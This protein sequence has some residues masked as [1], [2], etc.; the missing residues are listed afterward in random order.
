M[1]GTHKAEHVLL[2]VEDLEAALDFYTDTFGLAEVAREED[3]VYLGCGLDENYDLGLREDE[4][5]V[6]HVGVRVRD[7]SLLDEY[8][9]RLAEEGVDTTRTGGDE[10]G[11]ERGLRFRLPSDLAMELVTVADREYKHADV[12]VVP[13]R[14]GLAPVDINHYT[15]LSPNVK[16][17][18]TFLRDVLDFTISEVVGEEWRGGA[19]L[20]R[21]DRH[22]DVALFDMPGT[23][24]SHAAHHHTAFSVY[25]VDHMIGIIDRVCQAGL[26]L[27]LGI[28]RHYAGDNIYSYFQTPDGHRIE[29]N[30]QM[31]ELDE[32]TP[33]NA[34]EDIPT[35]TSAWE[36]HL[37]I[38]ESFEYG[39]GLL[40]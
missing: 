3:T 6:D 12:E 25:G 5:G 35:A 4:Q 38:P 9:A 13:G 19:F 23:P 21:G 16:R 22:H 2:G 39:S 36:E 32:D 31:A 7:G 30:T 26:D 14:G 11:Q 40:R 28:G 15:F 8:E 34:V 29:L 10:P 17:D 18:A 24:E 27:E 33:T 37:D 20:R 1:P